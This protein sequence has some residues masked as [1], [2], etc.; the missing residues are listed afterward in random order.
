[1]SLNLDQK[2][3][4][5]AEVADIAARAHAAVA[6]DYRG[7]TVAEMT[8]LRA[9][10]RGSGVYFRVVKNT[11]ARRAITGTDFE[12]LQSDLSGPLALAFSMDEPGAAARLLK[13]ATKVHKALEVKLLAFGGKQLPVSDMDRLASMPTREQALSMLMATM[14]APVTKLARTFKEVPGKLVRTLE[15][16]RLQKSAG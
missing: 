15:A 13:D 9:K 5:V 14:Q 8:D 12:C 3:A 7:L 4:V 6:V 10:A 1:M 2:K 11:L 16:V